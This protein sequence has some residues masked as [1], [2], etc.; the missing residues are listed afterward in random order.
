[1]FFVFRMQL[2]VGYIYDEPGKKFTDSSFFFLNT[3][4]MFVFNIHSTMCR[5]CYNEEMAPPERS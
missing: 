2:D 3:F 1:M 4:D 5:S